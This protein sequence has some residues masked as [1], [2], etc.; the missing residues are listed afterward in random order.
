MADEPLFLRVPPELRMLIYEYL[1]DTD[2]HSE[3]T[4]RN[5]PRQ[6]VAKNNLKTKHRSSY[7]VLER[8]FTCSSYETTYSLETPCEMYPAIMAV[9]RR[10][11]EEASHYL[12]GR[13]SFHFGHDLGAAVPFLEDMTAST[14][15]LIREITLHKRGPNSMTTGTDSCDWAAICRCLKG[16][17]NLRK[18]RLIVEGGRPRRD[19]QGPRELSVSDLRLLYSTRHESLEWARELSQVDKVARVEIAAQMQ[20]MAEPNTSAMLVYAA[21]SAS[22]E[23]SLV[24]FLRTELGIPAIFA[25]GD[26]GG[27]EPTAVD[28]ISLGLHETV[29]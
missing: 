7:Y 15:D 20:P 23:T 8:T 3:L 13:H 10:V 9:N 25:A 6:R 21:L 28:E 19:W 24:E 27:A 18:L 22:I 2:G 17:P 1:L 29:L 4:I 26:D 14:R 11:R 16:L 5:L 12:Y